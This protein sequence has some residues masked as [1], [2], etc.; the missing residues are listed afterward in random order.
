MGGI[1]HEGR[2][3][4]TCAIL[5]ENEDRRRFDFQRLPE[6]LANDHIRFAQ[7]DD[8]KL[9]AR[10]RRNGIVSQKQQDI[11]R[12]VKNREASLWELLKFLRK[13]MHLTIVRRLLRPVDD[14]N[15]IIEGALATLAAAWPVRPA[16]FGETK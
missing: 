4:T 5:A 15:G 7:I 14:V 11:L 10:L 13:R 16:R 2:A 12:Q 3:G 8:T 6:I 9:A 1:D